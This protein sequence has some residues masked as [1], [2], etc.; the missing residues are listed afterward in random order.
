MSV[1]AQ[2]EQTAQ[3]GVRKNGARDGNRGVEVTGQCAS[4]LQSITQSLCG[5]IKPEMS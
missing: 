3:T 5:S 4:H 1:V 2:G